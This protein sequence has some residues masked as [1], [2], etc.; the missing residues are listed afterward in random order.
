[1]GCQDFILKTAKA[2]SAHHSGD[3]DGRPTMGKFTAN[4]GKNGGSGEVGRTAFFG[5]CYGRGWGA[6]KFSLENALNP[7]RNRVCRRKEARRRSFRA[8]QK[9]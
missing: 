5:A 7:E 1:M 8:M 3:G 9:A 4:S 6:E 2:C